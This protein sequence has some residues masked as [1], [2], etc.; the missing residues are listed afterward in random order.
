MEPSNWRKSRS[1]RIRGASDRAIVRAAGGPLRTD[2]GDNPIVAGFVSGCAR[3]GRPGVREGR[4]LS[5]TVCG[6]RHQNRSGQSLTRIRSGSPDAERGKPSWRP[7][8]IQR[9]LPY[10]RAESDCLNARKQFSDK[11]LGRVSRKLCGLRKGAKPCRSSGR[12][13]RGTTG[14]VAADRQSFSGGKFG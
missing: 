2:P 7:L 3:W 5:H 14:K 13:V 8:G 6:A 9:H 1:G 12:R 10:R 11:G 4:S